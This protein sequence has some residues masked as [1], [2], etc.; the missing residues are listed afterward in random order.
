LTNFVDLKL[1]PVISGTKVRSSSMQFPSIYLIPRL[2]TPIQPDLQEVKEW[3]F[4]CTS[5]N[6]GP[7]KGKSLEM[8][9]GELKN[10][11]DRGF[12][13]IELLIVIAII[14]IIAAIA[15]PNLLRARIAANESSAASGVRSITVA[16]T[17][18]YSAY[19]LIG[20][21]VQLQDLG[22]TSP[23]VPAPTTACLLDNNLANAVPGSAGH[24]GY[25]FLATGVDP[26]GVG[27]NTTYVAGATP[28]TAGTTGARDFCAV[29]DG[30]LRAQPSLGGVPPNTLAPCLAFTTLM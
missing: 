11:R 16:E 2:D 25:Q 5:I 14:L 26:G 7:P 24:S 23:C 13:L 15:I 22:K 30:V 20:Y 8:A 28:M 21:A 4:R 18:Y 10:R 12:S 27:I 3:H 17:S 29:A 1:L 9:W 6:A 19:P